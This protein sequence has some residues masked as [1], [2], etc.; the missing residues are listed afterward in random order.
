MYAEKIETKDKSLYDVINS[1]KDND[2]KIKYEA[3]AKG[4]LLIIDKKGISFITLLLKLLTT[5]ENE[6]DTAIKNIDSDVD[7]IEYII[8][9]LSEKQLLT[10]MMFIV[11]LTHN[12]AK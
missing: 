9:A 4:L 2:L 1:I 11:Q 6:I 8:N 5:S 12:D 10:L 7:C 3:L